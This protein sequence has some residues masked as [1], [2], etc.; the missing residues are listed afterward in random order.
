ML[1]TSGLKIENLY[2]IVPTLNFEA[3]LHNTCRIRCGGDLHEIA[4]EIHGQS[5]AKQIL[6]NSL[7]E[8]SPSSESH[9]KRLKF[10]RFARVPRS[11][12]HIP[13]AEKR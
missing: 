1:Y 4:V 3:C 7:E 12:F 2:A 11:V 8:S 13:G 9:P 6:G 5:F 10:P